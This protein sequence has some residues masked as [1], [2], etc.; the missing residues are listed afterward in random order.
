M[1]MWDAYRLH[2]IGDFSLRKIAFALVAVIVSA[3]L[4]TISFSTITHAADAQW[5]GETITYQ[6]HDYTKAQPPA[7]AD[8]PNDAAAVYEYKEAGNPQTSHLIF[9]QS[10]TDLTSA[11]T[12]QYK[13]YTVTNGTYGSPSAIT[14]IS[15]D[16]K[17]G[18]PGANNADPDKEIK[19]DVKGIGW[20]ICPLS[21][22]IAEGMDRVFGWVAGYL[23]VNTITTDTNSAMFRAWDI[24]RGFANICFVL[25]FLVIIYAQITSQGLNNYEIKRM[26]PKLIIAS[27]L[28]NLSYYI[29]T[30]AVDLSNISGYALQQMFND[31]RHSLLDGSA[32][33]NFE[34][35]TWKNVTEY[36]LSGGTA[37]V[38]TVL[39]VGALVATTGGDITAMIFLLF[40]ILLVGILSVLVALIVLAARQALIT[41]LIIVAPLAFVAYLLPN[42]EK[43]FNK[44]RELLTTMLLV[45][46]MFSVLFGGAQ[47]AAFLIWKNS[48]GDFSVSILSLAVQVAP[49]AI[50]PF[51]LKFSGS[52]LGRVAGMVNNPNKGLI[53]RARNFTNDRVA[54]R[55]ARATDLGATQRRRWGT[56]AMAYRRE[57][58][59]RDREGL[60]KKYDTGIDAHWHN[61]KEAHD[62][63]AATK[64]YALRKSVGELGAEQLFERRKADP[65]NTALRDLSGMQRQTQASIKQIQQAD[66]AEWKEALSDKMNPN[67]TYAGFANAARATQL[68]QHVADSRIAS[69]A[70]MEQL[71]YA[72]RMEGNIDL[73]KRAGGIDEKFGASRA[74]ATAIETKA[75]DRTSGL[76]AIETM[77]ALKNPSQKALF[78]MA[79]GAG[80]IPG[81]PMTR[82]VQEVAIKKIAGGGDIDQIHEL[83]QRINFMDHDE[84]NEF[85]RTAF[86]DAL[87]SNSN[88]PSEFSAGLLE[89]MSQGGITFGQEGLKEAFLRAVDANAFDAAG[90]I[91]NDQNTI[92]R[93][94]D[95]VR[96]N[97][98]EVTD[99]MRRNMEKALFTLSTNENFKGRLGKRYPHVKDLGALLD[100][101]FPD[102]F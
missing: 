70:R 79:T 61:R 98:A 29:C 57:M 48:G 95:I 65:A 14:T 30:I 3:F 97:P 4:W 77:I 83:A 74:L 67:N 56:R 6:G 31:I 86:V 36:I 55:A 96:D 38:G 101:N 64:A 94:K 11:T 47:L 17:G 2:T 22:F 34:G 85:W 21:K 20:M 42:T 68:E 90:I 54:N 28:V 8:F 13:T 69:A 50:T 19:C 40:P 75:N 89:Q 7:T 62:I 46:P 32:S 92:E 1:I 37:A 10:G 15:I 63:E 9:F 81:V 5:K 18:P 73:Q 100:F 99:K 12:A 66:E 72:Q 76:K 35:T 43:W 41:V 78:K 88:K 87:R 84:N 52:L 60:K 91:S 102:D 39:G 16:A 26:I 59:R 71:E 45:F 27:I 53:D 82:E 24:A 80:S 44:W 25:A 51:L 33:G 49:L 93:L 23:V 58:K